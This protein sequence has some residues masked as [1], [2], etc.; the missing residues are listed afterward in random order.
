MAKAPLDLRSLA[1]AQTAMGVRVLSQIATQGES[2]SARVAAVGLLFERG[3]GK[4]AQVHSDE[5]GGPIQVIIRHIID[6][7]DQSKVKVIEHSDD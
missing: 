4:A 5:D 3:W 6:N 7:I 2:E 1:R